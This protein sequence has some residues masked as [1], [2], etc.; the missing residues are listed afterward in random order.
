MLTSTC[1]CDVRRWRGPAYLAVAD[2]GVPVSVGREHAPQ[3][4][5]AILILEGMVL[6]HGAMKVA[7]DLLCRQRT[8][9]HGLLHQVTI[10]TAVGGHF[11]LGSW[12][13]RRTALEGNRI[14]SD[15]IPKSKGSP[16]REEKPQFPSEELW[17]PVQDQFSG[18]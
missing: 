17:N 1:G 12:G 5:N 10:V 13:D 6:R 3:R 14:N 7:L 9:T 11:I 15:F 4:C 16:T 8:L 18:S 2:A